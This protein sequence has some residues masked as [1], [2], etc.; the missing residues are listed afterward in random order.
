MSFNP[1][2]GSQSGRHGDDVGQERDSEEV[3]GVSGLSETD[4]RPSSERDHTP[5]AAET[6]EEGGGGES[7]II[8]IHLLNYTYFFFQL[9][10]LS[11]E[12]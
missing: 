1:L 10:I 9:F 5:T 11:S 4:Q 8:Q 7:R 3:A 12:N 6:G 2:R